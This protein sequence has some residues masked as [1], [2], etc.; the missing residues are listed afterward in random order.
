MHA[1]NP[2]FQIQGE[3]Y[4]LQSPLNPQAD[5]DLMYAQY[6]IYDPDKAT[7][8]RSTHNTNLSQSFFREL[9][10]IIRQFNPYHRIFQTVREML[11]EISNF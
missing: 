6:F 1:Y 2:T 7:R 3:L 11:S 8:L 9:D 10:A 5:N 4:H